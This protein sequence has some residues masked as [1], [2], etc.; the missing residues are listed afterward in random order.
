MAEIAT[1]T[2]RQVA[3]EIAGGR[4]SSVEATRFALAGIE[5][6]NPELHA[7]N[8]VFAERALEKAAAVDAMR[9]AGKSLGLLGG[10]PISIKDN[11]CT[12]FGAT[13]CSSKMLEHFHAPYDATVVEKLEAAGA[14]IL[15]KTNLDEFA[16]GSSTENSAFGPSKNPWNMRCVPGGSSGGAAAA[17]AARLGFG[18]LGSDTGGSIRQPASLC[19]IVGLKPTYGL[20]SR[21]GLV[22][23]ASSLDQIGPMT[24]T[25]EDAALFL[26]VIAGHDPLDST[27][28]PGGCGGAP[29]YLAEL[30]VPIKGLRIGLPKEYFSVEG[31]DPAVKAAVQDAVAW[32]KAQGATLVDVSLPYTKYGIAAYYIIAPAEASSNLA[33]YDGVHYGHRTKSPADLFDLYAASRG[34]GFGAEVKRRIMLGTYALSSEYEDRYYLM[35]QK[36]RALIKR[37]FDQAFEKCDVIAG[38]TS[39]TA[40][41][42]FG[43]KT[44]NPLQMYLCDVFTVTCNIAGIAGL[45]LPC[46]FTGAGLPIGMQL[47]GPTFSEKTLLRTARQYELGHEWHK[48]RPPAAA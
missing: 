26:Q 10:V 41:F 47:L 5:R 15:G 14:V 37:D 11:M 35:A 29:D 13:T 45:S 4:I 21:Y 20:V 18:G 24:L 22:A 30:D 7:Y 19:G 3:R 12:K 32:Y 42:E 2:A 17:C 31:M 36:V 33:R 44:D 6:L 23:F 8:S 38:P 27:S 34:E 28:W 25:V 40:A 39:P 43:S 16:M 46:G 9:A 48:R 1:M